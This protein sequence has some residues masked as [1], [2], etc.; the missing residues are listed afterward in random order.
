MNMHTHVEYEHGSDIG[1]L[2][3]CQYPDGAN[4][5][6]LGGRHSVE[7]IQVVSLFSSRNESAKKHIA[8]SLN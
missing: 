3:A 5:I 6:A 4:L 8:S 2:R 7:V 1:V